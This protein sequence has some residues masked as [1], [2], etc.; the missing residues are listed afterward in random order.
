MR[1]CLLFVVLMTFWVILS[2]ETAPFLIGA[3]I[4]TCA[5][6]TWIS[7]R[8]EVVGDEGQPVRGLRPFLLY[9]PW[10]FW[11][12]MLANIDVIRRIW[13][14]SERISPRLFRLPISVRHP[15]AKTLYANSITLTPGTVTVRVE[16]DHLLVH[17]L[18][19]E[20]EAALLDGTME[21]RIRYMEEVSI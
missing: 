18:T 7:H 12:V 16:E 8:L 9:L 10:L 1:A 19:D 5:F 11:Q 2:G 17:A 21:E 14:P 6:A 20:A 15:V 4:F 3:G 13:G